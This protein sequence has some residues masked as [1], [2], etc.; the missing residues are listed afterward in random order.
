MKMARFYSV[1]NTCAIFC[2]LKKEDAYAFMQLFCGCA[3][4]IM[5]GISA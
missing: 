5:V 1:G 2:N 4:K 3:R